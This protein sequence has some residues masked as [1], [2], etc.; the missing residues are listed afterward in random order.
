MQ[1]MSSTCVG[2][3]P[4]GSPVAGLSM[5]D[6][7]GGAA[8][9]AGWTATG[10]TDLFGVA[11]GS[12]TD[13]DW[14]ADVD[15]EAGTVVYRVGGLVLADAAGTTA[16]AAPAK[17]AHT[18]DAVAFVGP[19]EVGDFR[20]WYF[21]TDGTLVLVEPKLFGL[22]ADDV[23]GEGRPLPLS[24][25]VDGQNVPVMRLAISLAHVEPGTHIAAFE[26]E[27]LGGEPKDWVCVDGSFEITAAQ[28]AEGYLPIELDGRATSKFVKLVASTHPISANATLADLGLE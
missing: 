6:A 2:S 14:T 4:A 7:G 18:V 16:L 28:K 13:V 3:A 24:F 21:P 1:V 27:S 10:W 25:D 19:G 11:P 23:V 12:E 26:C 9:F 15:F 17:A 5:R 20:A 8:V 22:D